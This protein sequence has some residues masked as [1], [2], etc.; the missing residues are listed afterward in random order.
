ML[1][2]GAPIFSGGRFVGA[3]LIAQML[4]TYHKA[5]A[6]SNPLQTPLVAEAR[7]TLY[8]NEEEDAGAV[9]ALDK[10]IVA[11]S[12][13]PGTSEAAG[14]PALIG[15]LHGSAAIEEAYGHGARSYSIAWQPLKSIDGKA[16]GSIGIARPARELDGAADAAGTTGFLVS[17]IASLLAGA[18]GFIF[19]RG[20]GARLDDLKDAAGRWSLG[21]L[22]TPARDSEP[23][24]AKWIP[25]GSLR[26]EVSQLAE[27]LDQ[28]RE[29][30]RQA[31][32]R[33][34]KR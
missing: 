17:A 16:I 29:S 12:V 15:T 8:R 9:I 19:G 10:A 25:A 13:P 18:A 23:F 20:L 6:G 21:E 28:M 3:V 4:N 26:D 1:E 11:S 27:Q 2:A 31:I 30:F 7:Q 22:S 33:I 34:R 32:E 24:L 5:R 14:G